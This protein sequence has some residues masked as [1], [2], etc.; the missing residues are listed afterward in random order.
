MLGAILDAQIVPHAEYFG[1]GAHRAVRVA[2]LG[3]VERVSARTTL[4]PQA[5]GY[6]ALEADADAHALLVLDECGALA[7]VLVERAHVDE[8]IAG[9]EQ[10]VVVHYV[11]HVVEVDYIVD[12]H[13]RLQRLLLVRAH[14]LS[15]LAITC[16]RDTVVTSRII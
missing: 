13:L 1:P 3:D 14:Q 10:L 8:R 11:R 6:A 4:A 7:A 5:G 12:R 9:R 16:T 2:V 15:T